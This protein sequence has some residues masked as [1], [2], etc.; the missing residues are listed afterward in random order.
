M[1]YQPVIK[2]EQQPAY[3]ATD[4]Q[5]ILSV[6]INRDICDARSV[7]AG[8]SIL[9]P[10]QQSPYDLHPD[11]EEVFYV[12]S[13]RGTARIDDVLHRIELGD[14]LYVQN[15]SYH[16]FI[17]DKDSSLRLFWAFNAHPAE[18]FKEKFKKWKPVAWPLEQQRSAAD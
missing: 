5:R 3:E 18:E 11:M 6:L 10:G 9:G 17:A 14:V 7:L 16:Q 15:G 12:I 4:S 1:S 8:M 13:G 2:P